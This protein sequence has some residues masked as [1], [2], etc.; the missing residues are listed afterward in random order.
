M[1]G[2]GAG[3]PGPVLVPGA[4]AL[5]ATHGSSQG[6]RP[7][8]PIPSASSAAAIRRKGFESIGDRRRASE[9][10]TVGCRFLGAA[11]LS[12]RTVPSQATADLTSAAV[13]VE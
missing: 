12:H 2:A 4:A 3:R 6:R 11:S 7:L 1:N 10:E 13:C 5:P 8:L 9:P